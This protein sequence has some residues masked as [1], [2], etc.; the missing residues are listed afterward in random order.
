MPQ[1]DYISGLEADLFAQLA[2]HCLFRYFVL[3]DTALGELPGI[4][5]DP[6]RPQQF[7][8]AITE[9]DPDVGPVSI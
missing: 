3:P 4:L 5:T 7:T 1:H 6:T 9:D 8:L 2:V